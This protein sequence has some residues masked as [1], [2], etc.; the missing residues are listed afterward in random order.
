MMIWWIVGVGGMLKDVG[1]MF[2]DVH[3]SIGFFFSLEDG[4]GV[5]LLGLPLLEMGKR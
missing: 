2:E 4:R 1:R 3:H 5:P